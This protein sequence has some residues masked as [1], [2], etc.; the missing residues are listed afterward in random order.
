MIY[1]LG[2][3]FSKETNAQLEEW[4]I[5]SNLAASARPKLGYHTTI[6]Y[7]RT[8]FEYTI[9]DLLLSDYMESPWERNDV[10]LFGTSLVLKLRG[11][12]WLREQ[13]KKCLLNGATSDYAF[14]QPHITIAEEISEIP[15]RMSIR[16]VQVNITELFYRE[17]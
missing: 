7:S 5:A 1:Y 8:P 11:A 17:W 12:A 4:R 14:Y 3:R 10:Q 6:I 9:Q 2:A 13:Y 15:T 16:P